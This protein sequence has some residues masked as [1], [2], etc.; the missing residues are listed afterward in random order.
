MAPVGSYELLVWLIRTP[1]A[2]E[3]E[4][5]A[6]HRVED[7]ACRAMAPSALVIDS[8][9]HSRSDRDLSAQDWQP[10]GQPAWQ[11]TT[12]PACSTVTRFPE[13]VPITVQRWPLTGSAWKP[14]IRCPNAS[15]HRCSGAPLAAGHAP[16][17]P[18]R[19]ECSK[20]P[21]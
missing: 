3:R 14:V 9:Q 1:G 16:G 5:P 19:G 13:P 10:T 7:T 21:T 17:S 11:P 8:G 18:M 12:L 15:S 4:S 20:R 6:E 2:V